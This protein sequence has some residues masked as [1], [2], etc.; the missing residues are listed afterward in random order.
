MRVGG[1]AEDYGNLPLGVSVIAH[2]HFQDFAVPALRDY[3]LRF[4]RLSQK[5]I[6]W[7]IVK[8]MEVDAH[9][10]PSSGEDDV[11]AKALGSPGARIHALHANA[12]IHV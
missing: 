5:D 2:S 8:D 4:A 12:M 10:D 7:T 9:F 11:L 1:V 3:I 6:K